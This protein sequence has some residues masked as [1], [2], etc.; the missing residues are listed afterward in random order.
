MI[1]NEAMMHE[2]EPIPYTYDLGDLWL[3]KTGHPVVFAVFLVGADAARSRKADIGRVVD[4]YRRSLT[5]LNSERKELI[6]AARAKYP[7]VAYDIDTY[8]RLL[9]FEFTAELKSALEFY[10]AEAG[11]MG[12]IPRVGK[13][14]YYG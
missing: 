9:R 12:L 2:A 6:N 8:Y 4:S 14:G 3:R 11:E 1:G 5:C 7:D 13:I 10:Y